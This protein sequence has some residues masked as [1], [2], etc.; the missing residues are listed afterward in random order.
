MGT[1]EKPDLDISFLHRGV[2]LLEQLGDLDPVCRSQVWNVNKSLAEELR[3][4]LR[5]FCP[6]AHNKRNRESCLDSLRQHRAYFAL[7]SADPTLEHFTAGLVGDV[8]RLRE[9]EKRAVYDGFKIDAMEAPA[10][11]R[12]QCREITREFTRL[13]EALWLV[14][15]V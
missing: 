9:D 1:V 6:E 7:L 14:P 13:I 15:T 2:S 4:F 3:K 10:E 5:S 8:T 11:F 12:I